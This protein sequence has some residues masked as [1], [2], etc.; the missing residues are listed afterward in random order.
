M[1]NVTHERNS[2]EVVMTK[3]LDAVDFTDLPMSKSGKSYTV[4]YDTFK[5][6]VDGVEIHCSLNM[7]ARK[8]DY[9]DHKLLLEKGKQER[10]EM[11]TPHDTD[12]MEQ[13]RMEMDAL[14]IMLELALN[15]GKED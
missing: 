11:D 9:E 15:G 8:D 1:L 2:Q 7:Y 3:Y 10:G 12:A 5:I 14:K 4:G 13:M 6:M